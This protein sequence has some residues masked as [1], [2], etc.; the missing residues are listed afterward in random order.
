VERSIGGAE[1][2]YREKEGE[3][4][5]N[6]RERMNIVERW[7]ETESEGEKAIVGGKHWGWKEGDNN[8]DRQSE[9]ARAGRGMARERQR[10]NDSTAIS[11]RT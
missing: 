8:D 7:S 5:W 11:V 9:E 1:E 6:G 3:D 10:G 4:R 2:S